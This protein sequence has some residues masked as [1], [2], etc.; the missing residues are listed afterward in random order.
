[1]VGTIASVAPTLGPVIGGYITDT[2]N[3]HWLFYV[4]L[5]PGV[6]ITILVPFLVDIDEPDTTLLRGA[7]YPGIALMAV[8]LATLEYVLEEGTRWNWFDDAII[9]D[10]AWVSAISGTLFVARSLT[11]AR[12]VVD[13]RAFANR[14]FTIGCLLSFVTGI[15][16]FATIFLTPLFLGYVRGYS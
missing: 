5:V 7:D 10:C 4:N 3:W 2:L 11:F 13:L 14:N 16:I 15:G 8:F 12:P 6:A 1:M 9:R